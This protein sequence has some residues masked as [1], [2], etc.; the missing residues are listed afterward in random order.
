[1]K[2]VFRR[3]ILILAG[4]LLA[5]ILLEAGLRIGGFIFLALQEHENRKVLRHKNTCRIV[6][7]GEST[8]ALG[9]RYSYPSQLEDILNQRD[10]GISFSVINKGVPAGDTTGV[11]SM[12][13]DTLDEYRP[14]IVITMIGVND[15]D[16]IVMQEYN[17]NV[18]M[19]LRS[20]RIYKLI[21][22]FPYRHNELPSGLLG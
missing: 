20:F 5:V 4:L 22:H 19:R 2:N 13:E 15:G 21:K 6:C 9:G 8:T 16:N 3:F 1:M 7:F 18:L 10:I 11:L 17:H 12:L 14:D